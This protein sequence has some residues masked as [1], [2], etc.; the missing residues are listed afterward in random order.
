[1]TR[2]V[3]SLIGIGLLGGFLSG[4][5]GIGGGILMVPL[6][7]LILGI[8]QRH[9]SA[10]SLTA[11]LPAA[12][13]GSITYGVQGDVDVVAA[14]LIAV[15]GIG[16]ALIGTRLLRAVPLGWLRWG[17]VVLLLL[18]AVRMVIEV[19]EGTEHIEFGAL[20]ILGLIGLGL[21]VG[22]ASGLF[23]IGGGVVIVPALIGLFG[24]GELIAKG[25]SLAAMIPTSITGTIANTRAKL[26]RPVDGLVVGIAAAAASFPGALVAHVLPTRL[27]HILFAVLVLIA[28]VQLAI[29]AWRA[30]GQK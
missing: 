4:T 6:F 9:A 24:V 20:S 25:T 10:L 21:I 28:A 17:F 27:S 23:G 12:I 26:V 1:M 7:V 13:V 11:V 8:D 3:L 18:V 5:F 22:I 30:R 29:R 14:A 2:R 15:G 16:G 19:P